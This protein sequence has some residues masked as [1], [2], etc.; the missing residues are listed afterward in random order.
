MW[1]K[2]PLFPTYHLSTQRVVAEL[3]M[4]HL[5]HIMSAGIM[6]AIIIIVVDL[7]I[8]SDILG[9]VVIILTAAL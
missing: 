7:K 2:L 5:G 8:F 4:E 1:A 3:R 9:I 6:L